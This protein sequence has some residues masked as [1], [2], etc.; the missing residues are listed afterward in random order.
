[1]NDI[2]H[3]LWIVGY[4]I[5]VIIYKLGLNDQN[6]NIL[7]IYFHVIVFVLSGFLYNSLKNKNNEK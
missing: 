1:M 6:H 4:S 3:V 7:A 2:I 5:Y